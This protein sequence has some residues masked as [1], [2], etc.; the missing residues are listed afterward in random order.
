M[1]FFKKRGEEKKESAPVSER[2]DVLLVCG[3]DRQT[4]YECGGLGAEGCQ[5][6]RAYNAQSV[7]DFSEAWKS[8]MERGNLPG[9]AFVENA[10]ILQ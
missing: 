3:C 1:L 4:W 6:C 8:A 7:E 2:P 10:F 5:Y 9:R